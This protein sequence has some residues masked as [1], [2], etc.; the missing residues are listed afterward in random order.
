MHRKLNGCVDR[1]FRAR[2]HVPLVRRYALPV[3]VTLFAAGVVRADDQLPV[4]YK[5]DRYR[6]IWE[7]N[8][9]TLVTPAAAHAA[10]NPFEK[11]FLV[12]WLKDGGKD[13][14]FVQN[15]ETNDTQKITTEPNKDNLRLL[16]MHPNADPKL[17][18]ATI[19]NGAEQGNVKFHFEAPN[20]NGNV[21]GQMPGNV[22]GIM[23]RPGFPNPVGASPNAPGTTGRFPVPRSGQQ[24]IPGVP[25]NVPGAQPNGPGRSPQA[26]PQAVSPSPGAPSQ[27]EIRRKRLPPPD[28]E[29]Q[30]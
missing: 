5:I 25:G 1:T 29:E 12:S 19:A 11:L 7:R 6:K 15:T 17:V 30:R 10:P 22:P 14:I 28:Q 23:P 24:P 2:R 20:P 26:L 8:P 16:Q 4:G 27:P 21:P 13:I 18:E 3:L 9:F